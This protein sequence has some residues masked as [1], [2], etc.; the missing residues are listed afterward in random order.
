MTITKHVPLNTANQTLDHKNKFSYTSYKL[1]VANIKYR[2]TSTFVWNCILT[3][4]ILLGETQW[5]HYKLISC[6]HSFSQ[7]GCSRFHYFKSKQSQTWL[8][9][10]LKSD[11]SRSRLSRIWRE[12]VFWSHQTNLMALSILLAAKEGNRVHCSNPFVVSGLPVFDKICVMA[13]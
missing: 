12:L 11:R 13:M 2:P 5:T 10:E 3:R 8:D 4:Q 6:S 7:Q 1:S 9:L